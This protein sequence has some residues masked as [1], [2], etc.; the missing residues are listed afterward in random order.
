[1]TLEKPF[2]EIG[3]A[4][5]RQL[6][7]DKVS[8]KKAIEYKVSLPDNK[9]ESKKEFLADVSSLANS[10]GGHLLFGIQEEDG[11]PVALPGIVNK[12]LDGQIL[13][14]ENL[15][16]D[17]IQP[18]IHGISMRKV[19]L[20][21]TNSVV[22]VRVPSSWSKPHVVNFQGHWRYYARN[23][24]GK[25]PLDAFELKSAYLATTTLGERIRNFHYDRTSKI[26]SDETP[27][28]L[29][30]K[31]KV[32]FHLIPFSAFES[33]HSLDLR[34][35][36]KDIWSFPLI[37]SSVSNYRYNID[38]LLAYSDRENSGA[39]SQVFRNGIIE[40]VSTAI[41]ISADVN[42]YIP[43]IVFE[44]QMI[45][46]LQASMIM[47][48][49]LLVSPPSVLMVSLVGVLGYKLAV[50]QRWDDFDH[51]THTIDRDYLMFPESVIEDYGANPA[52]LSQPIFNSLWNSAGWP[53][54]LGYDE[55][56]GEW[57][58]GPNF[59]R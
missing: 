34:L 35:L 19:D 56:S 10:G 12:D 37:Y 16:R 2:D 30:K 7:E 29:T 22:V 11:I 40:S 18:R 52:T 15:L 28:P 21:S 4:D 14:L 57:G 31:T 49:R 42:P 55:K 5:L 6:I 27:I 59:Q 20:D 13:R 33:N 58:K 23:S 54:S 53:R 1:M 9:Y 36:E 50:K 46:T 47:H 17:G 48:Q 38:G 44:E 41:F 51:Q 8:E 43:S 39:Y 3:E 25:Y 24:A 26:V 45:K 32:I